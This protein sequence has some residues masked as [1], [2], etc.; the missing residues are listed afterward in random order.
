MWEGGF[1]F[2]RF[3]KRMRSFLFPQI[4]SNIIEGNI[5][6]LPKLGEIRFRK[7]REIPE[8]F[9]PKQVRVIKKPSGYFILVGCSCDVD[10]P[11]V[12]AHGYPIGVDLGLNQFL[13]TSEGELIKGH[14]G[15]FK[16][17]PSE[18]AYNPVKSGN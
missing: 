10:V 6:K 5:I 3:K 15:T 1:G 14:N 8:G 18:I 2:P 7:S 9:L 17:Y 4:D 16:D 12:P 13:A 11:D